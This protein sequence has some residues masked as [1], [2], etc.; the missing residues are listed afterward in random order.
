MFS[1]YC[2]GPRPWSDDFNDYVADRGYCLHTIEE[3]SALISDAGF[4]QV[5][6]EDI[7]PRFIEIL[8]ADLARIEALKLDRSNGDKLKQSWQQKLARAEAGHQR[9]GL[10]SARKVASPAE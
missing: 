1:D 8:H 10:F 2:C 7:T 5:N 4:E 6:G 9:W 3:Y